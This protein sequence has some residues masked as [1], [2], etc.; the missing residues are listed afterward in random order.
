MTW[1]AVNFTLKVLVCRCAHLY[2][3]IQEKSVKEEC[4]EEIK[5][6]CEEKI[7]YRHPPAPTPEPIFGKTPHPYSGPAPS[8]TVT[9]TPRGAGH[10]NR[11]RRE[12]QPEV[13]LTSHC[14][15]LI[16]KVR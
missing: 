5:H 7:V 9:V 2:Q 8:P 6:V 13:T 16:D 14:L 12:T 11:G 1:H 3:T 10:L 4:E 15:I